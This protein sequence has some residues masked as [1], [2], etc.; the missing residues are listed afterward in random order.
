M[1]AERKAAPAAEKARSPN[2]N[3]SLEAVSFEGWDGEAESRRLSLSTTNI[4]E[5]R[6]PL[7]ILWASTSKPI[8]E[9]CPRAGLNILSAN[10]FILQQSNTR[11][12]NEQKNISPIL[13]NSHESRNLIALMI[14]FWN[15]DRKKHSEK[16]KKENKWALQI[17]WR[18][19]KT[20]KVLPEESGREEEKKRRR[21]TAA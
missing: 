8:Q 15:G 21:V 20:K 16:W 10:E 14:E 5:S 6:P 7:S 13:N 2:P 12:S 17:A 3:F 19:G 4:E 11:F 9:S 18:T 1:T